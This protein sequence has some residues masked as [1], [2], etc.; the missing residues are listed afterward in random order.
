MTLTGGPA[1][2][3]LAVM[4]VVAVFTYFGR[5]IDLRRAQVDYQDFLKGVMNV[6]GSGNDEEALSICDDVS[7]PVAQVVATAIRNRKSGAVVLREAVDAQGRAE[8]S[9]LDRRLASLAIIG[10]IAPL[11]G[12]LGTVIEFMKTVMLVNA[13]EV[14][15]RAELMNGAMEAMLT[16]AVGIGVAVMAIVMYGSLRVRLD[17]TVVDLES[18]ASVIVGYLTTDG[19]KAA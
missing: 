15:S 16:T 14:V 13:S 19:E 11:L 9:R 5:W 2:W 8:I 4:A 10:Q 3:I 7:A 1:I 12:L 17:R 6:L 18:A